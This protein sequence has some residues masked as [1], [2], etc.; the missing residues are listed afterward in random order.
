MISMRLW[1]V[2]MLA[3]TNTTSSPLGNLLSMIISFSVTEIVN[4][5]GRY[6]ARALRRSTIKSRRSM[7]LT[8][9]VSNITETLEGKKLISVLNWLTRMATA[10]HITIMFDVIITLWVNTNYSKETTCN[11]TSAFS[12]SDIRR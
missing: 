7:V 9:M 12:I 6:S 1:T 11:R 8:Y 3:S 2:A 10:R 5:L 4:M